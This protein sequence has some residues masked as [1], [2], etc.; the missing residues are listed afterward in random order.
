MNLEDQSQYILSGAM[1]NDLTKEL[2][3]A[4]ERTIV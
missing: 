3:E 2:I 1:Y 4:R